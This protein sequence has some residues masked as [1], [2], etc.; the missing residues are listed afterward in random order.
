M[1][2]DNEIT[3]ERSSGNVFADLGIPNAEEYLAK[4]QLAVKIFKIISR[5]RMTHAAAAKVLGIN[6][7]TVSALLSG[8]LDGFSID[9]LSRFLEILGDKRRRNQRGLSDVNQP[10]GIQ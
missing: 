10:P 2:D 7:P 9:R 8:R 5:R 4:S 6:Q 1:T 3:V